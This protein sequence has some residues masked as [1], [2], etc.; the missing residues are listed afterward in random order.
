MRILALTR[1]D[2]LGASS[3]LRT[4]QY[5]PFLQREG[6]ELDIQP[7]FDR[8]YLESLYGGVRR[9]AAW[10]DGVRRRTIALRGV[11]HDAVWI[12]KEALPWV[13]WAIEARLW[14]QDLPVIVDYDDAIFH[15]YDEHRS[16]LVRRVFGTKIDKIMR[17]ADLVVAGSRYLADRASSAGCRHI[18]LIP[19]VIDLDRYPEASS[20]QPEAGPV[21]IGWIGSPS[22]AHYLRP[23]GELLRQM[24]HET[25]IDCVAIG[26]RPDQLAGGPFHA[27]RWTEH[28]EVSALRGLDIGIMPLPDEPW[29]RGKC[30]YKLIQYMACGLPV[31]ASPVG[32]NREIV[33]HGEN[34]YLAEGLD[35]WRNAIAKLVGSTLIRRSL[36][37]AGRRGVEARFTL[38]V[39]SPQ[40]VSLLRSLVLPR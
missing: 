12:E 32:A 10:L 34:G 33:Q 7:F 21:R 27:E 19:T 23:I 5:Q 24:S 35:E 13:P 30:G 1:Y 9:R 25:P 26:A 28:S 15:R 2:D 18:E 16:P 37:S 36:G 17:R 22:T 40:L 4:Y 14:P 29:E 6:I 3:R 8:G 38:Q 11:R 20:H 39:Q 31:I